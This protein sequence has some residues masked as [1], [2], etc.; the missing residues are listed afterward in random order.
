MEN[1]KEKEAP[2][3]GFK[4]EICFVIFGVGSLLAWNAILSDYIF[5]HQLS[6]R[7]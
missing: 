5:F 6:R 3:G 4:M 2:E 7:L 1:T